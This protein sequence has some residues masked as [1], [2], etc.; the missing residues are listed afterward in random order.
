MAE[1]P[2]GPAAGR[3]R[4]CVEAI[5]PYVPGK[6]AEEVAREY[7]ISEVIKLASN[8]NPLG[9]SPRAIEALHEGIADLHV[10]PDG[11][12]FHLKRAIGEHYDVQP[13]QITLGNGSN[14]VLEL[15]ARAYLEPGVNAV[16]SQHAF[17]VYALATQAAGAEAKVVPARP[18][19]DPEMPFGADLEAM[20]AAVDERTRVLF[21][22]N[23]NNPTGTW[24]EAAELRA[25]LDAVPAEV[26]VVLDEAY[27]EYVD[28]P[29][30]PDGL[31]LL[32]HYP[33]LV[34]T[35]TF[36]KIFG[37]AALRVGF[38]VSD[39]AIASLLDRVRHPFNVN[40]LALRAAEAALDD[41]KF[42]AESRAV[43]RTGLAQWQR[44][45]EARG[46]QTVPSRANFITVIT[47]FAAARVFEALLR[48]GVIVRPLGGMQACGGLSQALRITIGTEAQNARAIEALER[49]LERLSDEDASP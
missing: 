20:A 29:A 32:A 42:I 44:A 13:E 28:D 8:E 45:A 9:P 11:S 1:A 48:E 5:S 4:E 38:A 6:P 15:V 17:A 43:N 12:G 33:N 25:M 18:A 10:Y 40:A 35:R 23:P 49:V 30:F 7:G 34:V 24:V 19:D 26:I 41:G 16:F 37:L 39:P 3:A 22:A 47:P 46:W 2:N 31:E 21:L 14:D 36:S 27:T